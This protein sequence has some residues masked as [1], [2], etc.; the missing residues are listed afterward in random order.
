MPSV[1]LL[2]FLTAV[3]AF[4]ANPSFEKRLVPALFDRY[5]GLSGSY[6]SIA[7][8]LS[9]SSKMS[10]Q[11]F[12]FADAFLQKADGEG[13]QSHFGGL[14]KDLHGVTFCRTPGLHASP[15]DAPQWL[16][17]FMGTGVRRPCVSVLLGPRE[18]HLI[19]SGKD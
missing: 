5:R 15:E 2:P 19:W 16:Q 6:Y 10:H 14:S 9:S 7:F 18:I 1:P 17:Y 8:K 13:V 12:S 3:R 11:P 4:L